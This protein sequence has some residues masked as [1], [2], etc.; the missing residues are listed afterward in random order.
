VRLPATSP[1]QCGVKTSASGATIAAIRKR[2]SRP[3]ATPVRLNSGASDAPRRT[4]PR[5]NGTAR[6]ARG[7]CGIAP[8]FKLPSVP[9]YAQ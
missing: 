7:A 6:R 3:R 5:A 8:S 9:A 2:R 4:R 1:N